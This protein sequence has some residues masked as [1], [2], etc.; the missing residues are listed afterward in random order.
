MGIDAEVGIHSP[1]IENRIQSGALHMWEMWAVNQGQSGCFAPA[2]DG[3]PIVS[4]GSLLLVCAGGVL[5]DSALDG[6]A[7]LSLFS[8][9]R[10]PLRFY[11]AT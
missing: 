4:V 10:C 6:F 7:R 11:H 3:Q 9:G 2:R 8:T 5:A 1:L